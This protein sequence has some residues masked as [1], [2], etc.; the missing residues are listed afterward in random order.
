M[1]INI[2]LKFILAKVSDLDQVLLALASKLGKFLPFVGGPDQAH[3]LIPIFEALCEVE[4]IT[5][6]NATVASISKILKHLGIVFSPTCVH[7]FHFTSIN[8]SINHLLPFYLD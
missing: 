2:L 4:E 1:L 3:S 7:C 8:Q 5:V 6:R